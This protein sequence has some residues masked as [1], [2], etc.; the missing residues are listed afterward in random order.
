MAYGS[1]CVLK[2]VNQV[3]LYLSTDGDSCTHDV[4]RDTALTWP[5]K[6]PSLH[7]N[8]VI[9][10]TMTSQ[11]TSLTIVYSTV[12]PGVDQRKLQ[13]SAS[14][15]FVRGIHRWPVNS[16]HKGTVT[17]KMPGISVNKKYLGYVFEHV[18]TGNLRQTPRALP[19]STQAVRVITISWFISRAFWYLAD[20]LMV[21]AHVAYVSCYGRSNKPWHHDLVRIIMTRYHIHVSHHNVIRGSVLAIWTS[22]NTSRVCVY[23]KAVGY[24][25]W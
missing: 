9:M 5:P 8:D 12:Y 11:I 7:Y 22:D 23:G 4:W 15:A 14:L 10:S 24:H 18:I 16:P 1:F 2:H 19:Y 21:W 25:L 17:R 20:T 3:L 6:I 13:S